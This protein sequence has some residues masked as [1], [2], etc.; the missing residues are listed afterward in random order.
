MVEY[1]LDEIADKVF[2]L[3]SSRGKN[4]KCVREK[5]GFNGYGY[6]QSLTKFNCYNSYDTVKALVV[7]WFDQRLE[8][9]TLDQALC[10]YNLGKPNGQLLNECK[11]SND[12]KKI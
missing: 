2:A 11:Y 10:Y 8:T 1:S 9:M 4:D 12:F 7:N 6:G 3:E 5:M